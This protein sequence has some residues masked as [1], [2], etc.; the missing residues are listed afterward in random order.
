MKFPSL[1]RLLVL[2]GLLCLGT[3]LARAGETATD[4][5]VLIFDGSGSMNEKLDEQTRLEAAKQALIQALNRTPDDVHFGMLAFSHN[6]NGWAYPLGAFDARQVW[7][8]AKGIQAGGGTPLGAYLKLAADSLLR[9]REKQF[10]YGTYRLLVITDGEASDA[11]EMERYARELVARG[12]TL[13]VIG[14]AMTSDRSLKA[15]AHVYVPAN[16]VA[17][18]NR[19]MRTLLAEVPEGRDQAA[20]AEDPYAFLAGFGDDSTAWAVIDALGAS[21]NHPLGTSPA[22]APAR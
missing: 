12:I 17:D 21:G 19:A 4:H 11:A 7:A 15:L 16:N 9:E 22:G 1:Q 5:V 14:V 6:T 2:L 3:S 8:R 10:N 13:N 18:L 20:G